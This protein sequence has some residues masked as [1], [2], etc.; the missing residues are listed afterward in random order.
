[1]RVG[2]RRVR[3]GGR[4]EG[5]WEGE[6]VGEVRVRVGVSVKGGGKSES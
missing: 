3:V 6:E 1:M 4:G 2:G 5:R